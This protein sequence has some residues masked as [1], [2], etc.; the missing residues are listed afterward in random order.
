M[1]I[2]PL[3]LLLLIECL[4]FHSLG[5]PDIHQSS[6]HHSPPIIP[7]RSLTLHPHSPELAPHSSLLSLSRL[8]SPHILIS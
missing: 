1:C 8:A 7:A 3:R 5:K 4:F 2:F 6:P